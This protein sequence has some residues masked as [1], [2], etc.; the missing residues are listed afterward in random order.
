MNVLRLPD[1]D[2]RVNEMLI[3]L[4]K[5]VPLMVLGHGNWASAKVVNSRI[6]CICLTFQNTS[7]GIVGFLDLA[8]NDCFE[9][10]PRGFEVEIGLRLRQHVVYQLI[11]YSYL[12]K[13]ILFINL[14]LNLTINSEF[15]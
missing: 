14:P 1:G 3:L 4:N 9:F 13:I 6:S 12:M 8:Y 5:A 10:P 15:E 2:P 7:I 11:L